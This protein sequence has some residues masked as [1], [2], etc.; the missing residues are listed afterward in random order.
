MVSVVTWALAGACLIAAIV[1]QNS[2]TAPI[3]EGEVF[4][5]E[6]A[7]ANALI[8]ESPSLE[9]GVRRARNDLA[10]EAVS[11]VAGDGRVLAS[12][13]ATLDGTVITNSLLAYGLG[14][15]R[16]AALASP[17]PYSIEI[18]GIE[19]WPRGSILYE[20][21]AP[22]PDAEAAVLLHYDVSELLSRRAGPGEIQSLTIQLLAL[23]GVFA[24][25]G[26]AVFVGHTRAVRR[27]REVTI[28]SQLLREQSRRLESAN[29]ELAE[30]RQRA[31]NA[32]ALAEEKMRIRSEFV[33]MINHE[34]RTP[35]TSVVTGAELM[36]DSGLGEDDRQEL[37]D[38]MV[39]HGKRLNEMIDQIL[40]VATIENRGLGYE[41]VKTPLRDACESVG[42]VFDEE[43]RD[44]AGRVLVRT[45]VK[46]LSLIIASLSDNARTH[47]AHDVVVR[48]V[49]RSVI[50]PM[51]EVGDRPKEAM[52]FTV[53]DDGP[54]IDPHFLPRAFEKFEKNSFN[55]GT[56]L[57]LYMVQLMV[58]A[59]GGSVAVETSPSGTT[60]Q[61]AIPALIGDRVMEA[62]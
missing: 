46:T 5:G 30:A 28:E 22:R 11:V 14:D 26:T 19:E 59:L 10:V 60:F 31:E 36:R 39:A 21:L 32:L 58:V 13:S 2:A 4:V 40:A 8:A 9:E 29:A 1:H 20:V 44:Y 62:V 52:Y 24:L 34:L 49:G 51:L 37:I 6:A 15:S 38:S 33:L 3:G 57:G 43:T 47:G 45:D 12:T 56:G 53:S 17:T 50:R 16:F 54:G 41:L 55:S 35:L 25:L 42:A 7:R 23:G 18:D 27:H 61:I 48:C